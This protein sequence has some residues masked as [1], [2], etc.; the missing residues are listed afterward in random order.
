MREG[1]SSLRFLIAGGLNTAVTYLMYLGLLKVAS[2]Q[3][4]YA[5]AFVSGIAIS[6][7]LSRA[8]VFKTH[9]GYRSALILPMVYLIQYSTGA[10]VVWAWVDAF[11]QHPMFAPAI[12]IAITLPLTYFLSKFAFVG[13]I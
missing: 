9:K 7:V 6:Y 3:I 1:G 8:Y 12:S 2:P 5:T 13:K 11:E 4:S 10:A